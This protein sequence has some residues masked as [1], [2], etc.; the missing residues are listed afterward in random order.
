MKLPSED[1]D[2]NKLD[3]CLSRISSLLKDYWNSIKDLFPEA[4]EIPEDYTIQKTVGCYVFHLLF[5]HIYL[6][7]KRG[8]DFSKNNMKKILT[9][10]FKNFTKA[11]GIE[12]NSEFWNRWT[13][14]P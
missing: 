1:F 8:G 6:L 4:F 11:T 3:E 2:T 5:P 12:I 10:T 9:K 7:L 13:G 14:N